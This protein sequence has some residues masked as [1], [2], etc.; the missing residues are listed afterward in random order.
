MSVD[1]LASP[2]RK[3]VTLAKSRARELNRPVL[4][5]AGIP[6]SRFDVLQ[7]FTRYADQTDTSLWL[8]MEGH[9]ILGLGTAYECTGTGAER[10][11]SISAAWNAI[12]Q[13]AVIEGNC[14]PLSLGGFRFDTE[15]PASSVWQGFTDG[16]LTIPRLAIQSTKGINTLIASEMISPEQSI[17]EAVTSILLFG[18]DIFREE[19]VYDPRPENII[20]ACESMDARE[21]WGCFVHDALQSL[22]NKGLHKIVAAR[23]LHVQSTCSIP[24]ARVINRLRSENPAACVFAFGRSGA[25]FIGATPEILFSAA[26][27]KFRTMALAG[28]IARGADEMEDNRLGKQLLA[29]KKDR[30]EHDIV[31]RTVR[32]TLTPHCSFIHSD[33]SP[34]LHKLHAVQHLITQFRGKIEAKSNLLDIVAALHP[35][36]AVGGLPLQPA[37]QFLRTHE[38]FDRGWYAGPVGWLDAEGNGEFMVALRSGLVRGSQALLFA[39]CGLVPGS[40]PDL[41]FTETQLKFKTMLNGMSHVVTNHTV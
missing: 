6:L 18:K 9:T 7:V 41:E 14:S 30:L 11:S 40:N 23:T 20:L 5:V 39:G 2:L 13:H 8:G 27:G 1:L 17:D 36:P 25:Y 24:V 15:R 4:A 12:T 16:T 19:M 31:V 34:S 10:F 3:A 38:D 35:T 29:S 32:E 28:S 21:R 26:S 22:S 37:L 33:P